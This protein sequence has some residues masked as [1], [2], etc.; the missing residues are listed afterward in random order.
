MGVEY[1]SGLGERKMHILIMGLGTHGDLQPLVAL[2]VSLQEA[3]HVVRVATQVTYHD[4]V[5]SNG[6]G[7]EPVAIDLREHL[8]AQKKSG[9]LPMRMQYRLARQYMEQFLQK[10]W[11]ASHGI[12]AVICSQAA[13][14]AGYCIA[15]KLGIPI[16]LALVSPFQM[17]S[18]Y[19][20][21]TFGQPRRW[22]KHILRE[23]MLWQLLWR[24]PVNQWRQQT[25]GLPPAPFR[26]VEHK[27][28]QDKVPA[29]Y[30]LSSTLLP[31]PSH[32]SPQLHITG[33]WFLDS[34]YDWLPPPELLDFLDKGP[35]PIGISF[36]SMAGEDTRATI[37]L[38]L[39][40]LSMTNQRGVLTGGW[41][42]LDQEASLPETVYSIGFIPHNWLFP[43]MAA[44]INHGG[45]GTVVTGL[46]AGRPTIIIPFAFSDHSFWAKRVVELGVGFSF[47]SPRKV[48]VDQLAQ[49]IHTA[50]TDAEIKRRASDL[51][52]QIRA[53]DGVGTAVAL[54]QQYIS[55][56]SW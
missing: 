34:L 8:R 2:G 28:R 11:D 32:W 13:R 47:E 7:F 3:G 26:G 19:H 15:E 18:L 37:D 14:I 6:L 16:F 54:F 42:N 33:E 39:T 46:K 48:T 25:L 51:G 31:R 41:G 4:L 1:L 53:E 10:T 5:V 21:K 24:T 49:S 23:Q 22:L 20:P 38:V 27:L 52:T 44:L 12:E 17:A 40:A 50:V 55:S 36:G 9:D 43:R 30:A 45:G 35:P 56:H 29:F